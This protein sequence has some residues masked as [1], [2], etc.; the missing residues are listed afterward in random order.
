MGG[1]AS[2]PIFVSNGCTRAYL[3]SFFLMVASMGKRSSQYVNMKIC[4]FMFGLGDWGGGWMWVGLL[5]R[6]VCLV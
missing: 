2:H 4:I 1:N 5:V 3:V 6:I